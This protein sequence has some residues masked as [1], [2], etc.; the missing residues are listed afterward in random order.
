MDDLELR[1]EAV[2]GT[3]EILGL[4][5]LAMIALAV[6]E[7]LWDLAFKQRPGWKETAANI[8]IAAVNSLL[9][10]TAYGLVF[11]V[12]LAIAESLVP[13]RLPVNAWS[14]IA[15]LLLADFTYYWMH[16]FEH[17]IRALWAYH[18]VHHS[19]P[20]F[21]LTTAFRLAWVEGLVEWVFFLP[22]ILLG[23]D[24]V[25]TLVAILVVVAYQTWIHTQKIGRLGWLDRVFNTPSV[26]RVHHGANPEYLDKNYG[27][28][29]I[30]WDRLF[31]TYQPETEPV[32][33]GITKPLETANPLTI[34]FGEFLAIARD[35]LRAK[36][37]GDAWG[38]TVR[39]PGWE[40]PATTRRRS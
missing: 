8:V 19:S 38:Y 21:N 2:S 36:S 32:T 23:F 39:R 7:I 25:Q 22:M 34:N 30:L 16:R 20:E 4:Y 31:G 18:S 17:E 12:A 6:I 40:P 24:L 35:C 10:R 27:G 3:L 13:Y 5:S 33:F 29:L 26:H 14:W 9:E 15:A 28:I 37:L 11:I 1:F